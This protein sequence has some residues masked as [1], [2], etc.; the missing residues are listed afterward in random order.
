MTKFSGDVKLAAV[1]RYLEGVESYASIAASIGAS[2]YMVRNWVLQ[3]EHQGEKAFVKSYTSYSVQFKLDV[4]N[5][6][7]TYGTSPNE[8]AAIFRITSPGLIRKWRMQFQSQGI[9]ALISKKKGRPAMK[10]RHKKGT[11]VEGSV[12][13][14]Q[15]E[16]ERLRMENAYFKKVE[17]LSS[18]QGK[19]T[20]QD[21]AQV[22]FELRTEFPIKA[23]LK[24]A[25]IPRSTY[26]YYVKTFS[27][28]DKHAELKTL[29]QAIYHEHKGRYGYRRIKDELKN[30]GHQVNHKKVQRLMKQL[31]LKSMVR[32]KKYRS[33]K[34]EVG[35]VAPNI[36]DR[37]FHADKPNQKWVT[38]ITEFKLFGEKLY[39]SPMLDLFNGEIVAYTIDSKPRYSLVSTMLDQAFK[40][41]TD[42]DELLIH[43]DQGWHYQMSKYQQALKE[44]NITQSMSR[45][46]NCY[47]NAVM[48]N[49]FGILKSE[50]LY[51]QEFENIEHFKQELA[52]YIDYY[53]NKRIKAKLKGLSPVQYRTQT[54]L[55][56]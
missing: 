22:V 24:L 12:E 50:F 56:A 11:P 1:Q 21:K 8:T 39:L 28:P 10:K 36:L 35:K 13:A 47:D 55:A 44:K 26:Y 34:G 17:C 27:R 53:N 37:N 18:K 41:L 19:I 43:S 30:L 49:F 48:E 5:Y 9:D 51:M 38:D 40:R 15:E 33:Y 52:K 42:E 14:L 16:L 46:G 29:I 31:G 3:Y 7:N 2:D 23:L 54:L 45:K 32:M 20:K 4:L 25:G 6:M